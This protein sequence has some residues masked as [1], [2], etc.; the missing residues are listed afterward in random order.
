ME[1]LI[2]YFKPENYKIEL[3]I[4]KQT[5]EV[6]GHVVIA[7]ERVGEKIKLHA[8]NLKIISAMINGERANV[9]EDKENDAIKCRTWFSCKRLWW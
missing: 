6:Q 4:N 3:R 2:N 5:E 9:S 8:K 7:G 1:R